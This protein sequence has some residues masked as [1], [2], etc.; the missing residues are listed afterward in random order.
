MQCLNLHWGTCMLLQG[1]F[2]HDLQAIQD[3]LFQS[4][5]YGL[6]AFGRSNL[7]SGVMLDN[8]GLHISHRASRKR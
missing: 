8:P 2:T 7:P 6:P 5:G 1:C 4:L 3:Y